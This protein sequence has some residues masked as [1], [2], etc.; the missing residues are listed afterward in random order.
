MTFRP[1]LLQ[2]AVTGI[3][4]VWAL[5]GLTAAAWTAEIDVDALNLPAH[6]WAAC[7]TIAGASTLALLQTVV[8]IERNRIM[9]SMAQAVITRPMYRDPTGPQ[10]VLQTVPG[11]RPAGPRRLPAG[12]RASSR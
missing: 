10:P 8:V 3:R 2:T 7:L 12:R 4:P 9:Q 11:E 5:T 6:V 1:A